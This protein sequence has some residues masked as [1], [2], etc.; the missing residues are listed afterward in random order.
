MIRELAT[1]RNRKKVAVLTDFLFSSSRRRRLG[2]AL[3]EE[4]P[5][6]APW[7]LTTTALLASSLIQQGESG[8]EAGA[9]R[10]GIA[11]RGA[12]KDNARERRGA[13]PI[14]HSSSA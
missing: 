12:I 7:S 4:R 5:G 2:W 10:P 9:V 6:T 11:P 14:E 8:T 13:A 3:R 1:I